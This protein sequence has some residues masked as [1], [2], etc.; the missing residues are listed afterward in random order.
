MA[1]P[2]RFTIYNTPVVGRVVGWV[3]G[4]LLRV[5][6]WRIE[7]PEPPPERAVFVIAPHT[8]YWDAAVLLPAAAAIQIDPH[9]MATHNLFRFPVRTLVRWLGG[10]PVDRTRRTGLVDAAIDAFEGADHLQLAVAPEGTRYRAD[11][12]KTGFYRIA[13]GAGVPIALAFADY[14]RKVVGIG[15]TFVPSGDLEADLAHIRD[16]YDGV[17]ARHPDRFAPPSL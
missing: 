17:T 10:I 16:F 15:G 9:W 11:R 12:W 1:R 13:E 5:F 14:G 7:V 3:L 4:L 6:G 2:A 8:S